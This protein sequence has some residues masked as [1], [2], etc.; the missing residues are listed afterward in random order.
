M[1]GAKTEMNSD[2]TQSIIHEHNVMVPMRD[3]VRLATDI[4]RPRREG[5]WPVL[6]TRVPYNKEMRDKDNSDAY[7]YIEMNL[8][9][10][11]AVEAG[12]A[13]VAQDTRGCFASEGTFIPFLN[14]AEDGADTITWCASQPWSTGLVGMFGVSYQGETQWQAAITQHPALHAIAPC[15][16]PVS[17]VLPYQGG[18]FLLSIILGWTLIN[19]LIGEIQQYRDQGTLT[20]EVIQE[21]FHQ[22]NSIPEAYKTLSENAMIE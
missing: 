6:L 14:E 20:Q 12:Y 5:R 21:F 7:V 4:F 15:Q 1:K 22:I 17:M 10:K 16:A 18:A 13:V 11:R 19:D 2:T 8:Q 9:I 3:G